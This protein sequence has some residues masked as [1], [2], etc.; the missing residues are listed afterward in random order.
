[1][2]QGQFESLREV[3]VFYNTL[4][5]MVVMDH[6]QETV[7]RPLGF[8]ENQLDDLESLPHDPFKP[9]TTL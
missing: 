8:S 9:E 5:E 1:M 2:H 6:H 4:E 3:L 7:L